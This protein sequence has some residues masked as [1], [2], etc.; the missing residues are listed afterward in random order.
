M[1]TFRWLIVFVAAAVVVYLL[2]SRPSARADR[3]TRI[4]DVANI[5]LTT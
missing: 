3:H 1:K 4:V 5:E 2:L